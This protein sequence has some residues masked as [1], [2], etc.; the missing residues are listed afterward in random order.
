MHNSG[1]RG[2]EDG[3]PSEEVLGQG[4]QR[5]RTREQRISRSRIMSSSREAQ[6]AVDSVLHQQK[7]ALGD[8]SHHVFL[9]EG[10]QMKQETQGDWVPVG[11]EKLAS[12][13]VRGTIL[14]RLLQERVRQRVLGTAE[15]FP[16]TAGAAP[17]E[18]APQ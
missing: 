2:G 8:S 13:V 7:D 6:D 10:L 1:L 11:V 5:T 18:D 14:A 12:D 15:S 17:G 4:R 9:L 3:K 16:D